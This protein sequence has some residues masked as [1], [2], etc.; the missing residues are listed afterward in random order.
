[1]TPNAIKR[2]ARH[3]VLKEIGGPGQQALLAAK[4]AIVGAGGLGGPAG[5][6]LAAAGVGHL[7]LIDDD[8]VATSNLQRQVQFVNTDVG[9]PKAIVM[10]DTL[11]DLNPD[12]SIKAHQERLTPSNATALLSGFDVILDG[13]DSF[14]TRF[15][16]N[17]AALDL[18][19]IL[20]SGALGRFDGQVGV[21]GSEADMPCYQ[22][23]IP[24]K[25]PGAETCSEVGVVGALAGI[26]GSMMALET[27]KIITGAGDSLAGKLWIFDGLSAQSRTVGLPK[28]PEC[29]ACSPLT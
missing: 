1:M 11:K 26:V 9:M 2:Y 13:T 16:I 10:A 22:C 6:Y 23:L 8:K 15:L 5:L 27:I 19:T 12:I 17:K 28:D 24:Q 25:P 3:L 7:S 20:V 18:K 29:P 4:V 14:E 21:F